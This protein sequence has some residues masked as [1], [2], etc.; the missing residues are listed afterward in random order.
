[1]SHTFSLKNGGQLSRIIKIINNYFYVVQQGT[2]LLTMTT[3]FELPG[4]PRMQ[5]GC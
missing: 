1:M 3:G 4:P 5:K 2:Q